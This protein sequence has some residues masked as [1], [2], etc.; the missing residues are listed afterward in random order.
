MSGVL[1]LVAELVRYDRN[2]LAASIL[3]LLAIS[4][5]E[6][7]GLSLLAPLMDSLIEDGQ[8]GLFTTTIHI[9]LLDV[10][11]AFPVLV[12]LICILYLAK[13]F[14]T[15]LQSRVFNGFLFGYELFIR[16]QFIDSYLGCRW[17]YLS[18][19]DS[20]SIGAFL[21]VQTKLITES[22]YYL[23]WLIRSVAVAVVLMTV[24]MIISVGMSMLMVTA[25]V[26]VVGLLKGRLKKTLKYGA[27]IAAD[28]DLISAE[29]Q[30]IVAN[31][32]NIK[33]ASLE[34]STTN[35]FKEQATRLA[36]EQGAAK[37]NEDISR[38]ILEPAMVVGLL[39][40]ML[41]G[42]H[43]LRMSP[44]RL[45]VFL[46]IC[47]RLM[48]PLSYVIQQYQKVLL[49]I[50]ALEAFQDK[51]GQMRKHVA[52]HAGKRELKFARSACLD[53]RSVTFSHNNTP[54]VEALSLQ[55]HAGEHVCLYGESGSGKT[56][57]LDII[58]G[59]LTPHEGAVYIDSVNMSE[60]SLESWHRQVSY[61]GQDTFL[62]NDSLLRNLRWGV[63][64]SVCLDEI[65]VLMDQ[66]GLSRFTIDGERSLSA[67][68]GERGTLLSGGERQRVGIVRALLRRP[69]V[70][71]LDE[72]T[73]ALDDESSGRIQDMIRNYV[74]VDN[75]TVVSI[76]HRPGW[77]ANAD[78]L[79]LFRGGKAE[80]VAHTSS[81]VNDK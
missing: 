49:G 27:Q 59:L 54:L 21:N 64:E 60:I 62:W 3:L 50:P 73:S 57:C 34:F 47:Y 14:L 52:T 9:G 20:G 6:G 79:Y 5:A 18:V 61:V 68:V 80:P 67:N 76:A 24:A 36:G 41:V 23:N 66:A 51:V 38:A 32:K 29:V 81:V 31:A 74:D 26:I 77:Q 65:L 63:P 11:V 45:L 48:P 7:F 2:K 16:E 53:I 10:K 55:V 17:D 46:G 69:R 12:G 75:G 56:T 37:V 33:A 1:L 25:F 70:M 40:V 4:V 30:G 8:D 28:T 44:G 43:S 35:S 71:L 39:T 19:Q 42:I 78:R 58:A 72:V 22:V 15:Y 13:G